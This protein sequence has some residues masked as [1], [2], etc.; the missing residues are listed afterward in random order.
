MR[1][2]LRRA[3]DD[4]VEILAGLAAVLPKN[5]WLYIAKIPNLPELGT[6]FILQGGTQNNLAAVKAQVDFIQQR[7]AGVLVPASQSSQG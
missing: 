6:R 7:F 1:Q 5:V 4:E 3:F 2:L